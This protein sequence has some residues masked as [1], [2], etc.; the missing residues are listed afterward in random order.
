M[1][2]YAPDNNAPHSPH[3]RPSNPIFPPFQDPDT[4]STFLNYKSEGGTAVAGTY[5]GTAPSSYNIPGM[6]AGA[7]K[8][9]LKQR[10][11]S[12]PLG[13]PASTKGDAQRLQAINDLSNSGSRS[14]TEVCALIILSTRGPSS[15]LSPPPPAT[16]LVREES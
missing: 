4:H 1:G 7:G 3:E 8:S 11:N 6:D 15:S 5:D 10:R 16:G 9:N 12:G 13:E 14:W 2:S